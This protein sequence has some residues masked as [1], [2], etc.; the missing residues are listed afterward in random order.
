MRLVRVF[1]YS[2]SFLFAFVSGI[3]QRSA[4]KILLENVFYFLYHS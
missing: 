2:L 1:I 4:E 3:F